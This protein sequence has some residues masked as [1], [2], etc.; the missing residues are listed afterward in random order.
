MVALSLFGLPTVGRRIGGWSTL[1]VPRGLACGFT[2]IWRRFVDEA[3]LS[4]QLLKGVESVV[5]C[6]YRSCSAGSRLS[7]SAFGEKCRKHVADIGH[8]LLQTQFQLVDPLFVPPWHVLQQDRAIWTAAFPSASPWCPA[9][10]QARCF[11][12]APNGQRRTSAP[13]WDIHA[14]DFTSFSTG[15]ASDR[16]SAKSGLPFSITVRIEGEIGIQC[17][18]RPISW[19]KVLSRMF[20]AAAEL[21]ASSGGWPA[22]LR[23]PRPAA[24]LITLRVCPWRPSARLT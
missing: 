14:A 24:G 9:C 4:K 3:L 17:T 12:P 6:R 8:G 20:D 11:S 15:P 13:P 2:T 16:T 19:N 10:A 1:R 23:N 18:R 22:A 7:G 21:P 5:P